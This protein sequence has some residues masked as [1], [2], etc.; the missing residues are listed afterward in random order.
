MM[1]FRGINKELGHKKRRYSLFKFKGGKYCKHFW[2]LRVY[3]KKGG[4]ISV[5]DAVKKGLEAPTNPQEVSIRPTDMP[6]R[7]AYPNK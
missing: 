5:K 2:E 3:K 7:G 4:R 6:N 1:S